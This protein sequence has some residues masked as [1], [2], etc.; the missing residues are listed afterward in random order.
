[1]RRRRRYRRRRGRKRLPS[2]RKIELVC[3]SHSAFR[4]MQA[5]TCISSLCLIFPR[6]EMKT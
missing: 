3:G 6:S 5:G 4:S 1:M 2:R